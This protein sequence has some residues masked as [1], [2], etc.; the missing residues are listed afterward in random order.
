[1][2]KSVA[3][4]LADGFEEIEALSVIDVIRR[5]N[6]LCDTVSINNKMVKST[7][8]VYVEA[9]KLLSEID[10]NSY[11]MLVLPGGLPGADNIRDNADI[12]N[13]IKEFS[14]KTNKY[15]AAI[16]A[17]PQVFK[18]AQILSGRNITSYPGKYF[19]DI[20]KE[21][22]YIDDINDMD[23][24]VVV[25]NNIITSRGPSCALSFAYKII[26]VLG[27]DSSDL[28][29]SM[30]YNDFCKSIIIKNNH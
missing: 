7:H 12:V 3:V 1:M 30:L 9:D 22:N 6:I 15:I 21:S 4:I 25:D 26:E 13:W 18:T 17:S 14:N 29:Q 16:C 24:M 11:D 8:G 23:E 2:N 19:K 20:L 5:A 28:K 10:K 27:Y